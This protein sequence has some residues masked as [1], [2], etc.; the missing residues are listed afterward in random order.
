MVEETGVEDIDSFLYYLINILSISM[1]EYI[2]AIYLIGSYFFKSH[3]P[4][5]D[6]DV[7]FLLKSDCDIEQQRRR[8]W[9]IIDHH[10]RPMGR[11]VDP[12][13]KDSEIQFYDAVDFGP[14]GGMQCGPIL[15]KAVKE[16]SLLLW[17]ED[18]R[19]K[20]VLGRDEDWQTDVLTFPLNWMKNIHCKAENLDNNRNLVYPLTIPNPDEKSCGYGAPHYVSTL[21]FHIARALVF[22]E[23]GEFLLDKS[24]VADAYAKSV[25]GQWT[26]FIRNIHGARYAGLPEEK[27]QQIYESIC[28]QMTDYENYF[29]E[30]LRVKGVDLSRYVE[31]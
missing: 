15:R 26:G 9:S 22:M 5:S 21:V 14:P 18:I 11:W 13:W 16:H 23:T 30:M 27:R 31:F 29:L 6:V 28:Q 25:N 12:M 19:P 24:K 17:G 20:I 7:C 2:R 8:L 1:G 10:C 4:G 3:Y